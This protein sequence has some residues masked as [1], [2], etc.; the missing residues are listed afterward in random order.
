[1][2]VLGSLEAGWPDLKVCEP[3]DR[4]L[5]GTAQARTT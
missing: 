2:M 5:D 3:A 1:M 4:F